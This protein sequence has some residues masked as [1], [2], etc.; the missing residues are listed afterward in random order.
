MRVRV[1]EVEVPSLGVAR[2]A[3]LSAACGHVLGD[4]TLL[5]RGYRPFASLGSDLPPFLIR[6]LILP[7]G[8]HSSVTVLAGV[9]PTTGEDALERSTSGE[10]IAMALRQR[11]ACIFRVL[12]TVGNAT[13]SWHELVTSL[14]RTDPQAHR[15]FASELSELP[16]V[17]R[18]ACPVCRAQRVCESVPAARNG[19]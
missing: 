14:E 10:Q 2:G 12:L 9:D 1:T 6:R 19:V 3:P 7:D 5:K 16:M 13:V 11:P 8:R 4:R 18:R 17:A 15:A